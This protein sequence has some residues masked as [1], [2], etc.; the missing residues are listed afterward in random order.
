MS[1]ETQYCRTIFKL[2][3]CGKSGSQVGL[4]RVVDLMTVLLKVPQEVSGAQAASA[5]LMLLVC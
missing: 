2:T 1:L 3:Q 5:R 4:G